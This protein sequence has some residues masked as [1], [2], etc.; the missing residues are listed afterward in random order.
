M[1]YMIVNW[2]E[3]DKIHE[4]YYAKTIWDIYLKEKENGMNVSWENFKKIVRKRCL[5]DDT[6]VKIDNIDL[7]QEFDVISVPDCIHPKH[8]FR[9]TGG[10]SKGKE[11][12]DEI[13]KGYY[14]YSRNYGWI[15]FGHAG[16]L[17]GPQNLKKLYKQIK[18][19]KKGDVV[20]YSLSTG[21]SSPFLKVYAELG[22]TRAKILSEQLSDEQ[23]QSMTLSILK[24]TSIEFEQKQIITDW[25]KKSS[26]SEEDLP[27]NIIN[28]YV[29][30]M[31]Y[32]KE[33]IYQVCDV[34]TPEVSCWI[35]HRYDFQK[36]KSFDPV[37]KF[38]GGTIPQ[39]LNVVK[40]IDKEGLWEIL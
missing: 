31:G 9:V 13:K 11:F 26:F 30:V 22:N 7:V 18:S 39:E 32:T 37:L 15:D 5:S 35:Y 24:I 6:L 21:M 2:N 40:E 3:S 19:A 38:P 33:K 34:F 27:S 23:A 16:L 12:V 4:T 1:E 25:L 29:E 17:G 10:K 36:N 14:G 28:F 8:L 20:T